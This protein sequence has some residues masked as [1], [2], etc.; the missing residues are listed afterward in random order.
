MCDNS[1]VKY[2][3]NILRS[4]PNGRHFTDDIFECIFLNG[5]ICILI[6]TSLNFVFMGPI[7]N[8][9]ALVPIMAWHRTGDKPESKPMIV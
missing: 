5:N 9:R 8:E 4:G 3:N 7:D 6:E 2:D 1:C